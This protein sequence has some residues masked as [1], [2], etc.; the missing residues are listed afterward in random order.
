MKS[1]CIMLG[2]LSR[3]EANLIHRENASNPSFSP[4]AR[5]IGVATMKKGEL[6]KFILAPEF[7]YGDSGSPPKIPEKSTLVFE[8]EL[9]SWTSKDDLFGDEGVI[10]STTKE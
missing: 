9:I 6:A 8:V 10:K 1:L 7:A 4:W 5:D 3:M 2:Q